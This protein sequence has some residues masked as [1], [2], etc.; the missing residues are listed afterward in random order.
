MHSKNEAADAPANA[1]RREMPV[2]IGHTGTGLIEEV[3]L[4]VVAGWTYEGA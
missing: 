4:L 2:Y 1:Q 3:G